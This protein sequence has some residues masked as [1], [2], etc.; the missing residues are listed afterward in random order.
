MRATVVMLPLVLGSAAWAGLVAPHTVTDNPPNSAVTAEVVRIQAHFDS[1]LVELAGADVG[2]L[3]PAQLSNRTALTGALAAYRERGLFP[4][5]YDF[6]GQSVPYFVDRKTGVLCA[7][8]HLLELTGRRDIVDRV[9]ASDNNVWVNNLAGDAE[10]ASWLSEQGISLA[11]AARIQVPYW[12]PENPSAD[13][14]ASRDAAYNIGS[15]LAF[16]A[17]GGLATWNLMG[18]RSGRSRLVTVAG[19][20]VGLAA[21]GYGGLALNDPTADKGLGALASVAG[22]ASTWLATKSFRQRRS[23][24]ATARETSA[25]SRR[26]SIVPVAPVRGRNGAGLSLSVA[27]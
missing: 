25:D 14:A 23:D 12:T 21:T 7:V 2:A 16:A 24:I 11:E 9:A 3:A 6:P 22:V 4:N 18:N 1:V 27:F 19:L 8:A 26:V 13:A 5:N 10:L 17:A 20:A 15:G